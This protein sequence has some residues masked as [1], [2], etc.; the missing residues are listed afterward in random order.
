MDKRYNTVGET[1]PSDSMHTAGIAY[2]IIPSDVERDTYVT[3]CLRTSTVSIFSETNGV[4]NRVPVDQST[5]QF[6]KFPLPPEQ[7]G[8]AV[9]FKIDAVKNRPIVD[10][11]YLKANETG[12]IIENQFK[13][14]RELSGD[15]VEFSGSPKDKYMLVNVNAHTAGTIDMIVQSG[16]EGGAL[17]IKIDGNTNIKSLAS[18]NLKQY[19]SFNSTTVNR[20]DETEFS[21]LEQ[22]SQTHTFYDK[23]H[24]IITDKL[25]INNGEEPWILGKQ[26][27]QFMKDFIKEV[28]NSTVTTA[29]GQMP[30]LNA[31]KIIEYSNKVDELLSSI[32]FIDK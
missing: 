4:S 19:L 23:N 25:S 3:E 7:F 28:G 11:L 26:W 8:S 9:S 12:N 15:I 14:G 31:D 16:D 22:D 32:A 27:S 29:L 30:L 1:G 13:V 18:T 5:I 10:G 20:N 24:N 6:I 21:S 2:V 17:N